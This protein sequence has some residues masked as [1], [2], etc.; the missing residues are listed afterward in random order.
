MAESTLWKWN[1]RYQRIV[2]LEPPPLG[3]H[4]PLT[5]QELPVPMRADRRRVVSGAQRHEHL[6]GSPVHLR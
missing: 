4:H 6:A 1:D 5:P 3:A 2:E